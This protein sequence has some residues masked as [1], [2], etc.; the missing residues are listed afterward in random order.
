MFEFDRQAEAF[1]DAQ[2]AQEKLVKRNPNVYE[3]KSDET[4]YCD[5]DDLRCVSEQSGKSSG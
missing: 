2:F 5:G 1:P 4:V 3:R